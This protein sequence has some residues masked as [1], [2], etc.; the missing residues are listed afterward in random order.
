MA[1]IHLERTIYHLCAVAR[2][3]SGWDL[4]NLEVKEIFPV[5]WLKSSY[6][7]PSLIS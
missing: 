3:G 2:H 4:V 5:K 7:Q 1:A 6:H